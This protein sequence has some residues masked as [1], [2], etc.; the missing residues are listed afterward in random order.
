VTA[1]L[2]LL[3]DDDEDIRAA[4]RSVLEDES[5]RVEDAVNGAIALERAR[6]EPRPSLILLDLMMPVMD[7]FAFRAAQLREPAI[8]DIPLVVFT[9][10]PRDVSAFAPTATLRKPVDLDDLLAV[11]ARHAPRPPA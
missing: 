5:Y 7:G 10:N 3:V 8:A 9:A 4:V 6:R 11:V 1:P 2:I